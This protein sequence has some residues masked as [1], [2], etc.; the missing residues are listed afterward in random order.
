MIFTPVLRCAKDKK[1]ASVLDDAAKTRDFMECDGAQNFGIDVS[2]NWKHQVV[3]QITQTYRN[4]NTNDLCKLF[5]DKTNAAKETS[6]RREN[7]RAVSQN[8]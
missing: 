4:L 8:I 3:S 2:S 1:T 6:K 7:K 5:I